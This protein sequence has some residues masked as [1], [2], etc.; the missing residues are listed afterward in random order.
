M[1][2]Q[3]KSGFKKTIIW[4]KYQSDPKI[5]ARNQYLNQLIDSS[6]Q[7]AN[8]LFVLSF[9]NENGRT[10]LSEYYLPKIEIKDY[11]VK[12]NG[13]NLFGKLI[14]NDKITYGIIRKIATGQRDDYAAGCLLDYPFLRI[15]IK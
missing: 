6:F 1:L 7:G 11:N 13:S 9:E 12:I 2:Q 8:I 3:L 5:Y 4:N 10:S 14:N 15:T